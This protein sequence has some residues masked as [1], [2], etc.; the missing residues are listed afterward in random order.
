MRARS[1]LL[2]GFLLALGA[3][4][5]A[6]TASGGKQAIAAPAPIIAGFED[7]NFVSQ[8]RFTERRPDDPIVLP[9]QPNLSHDHSFFGNFNTNAY[10][11]TGSLRGQRTSCNRTADTAAYWAPTLIVDNKAALTLDLAAYYRRSTYAPVKP[12]PS[13]FVMIG[14]NSNAVE[15]QSTKVTFWN[16]EL[17]G[18]NPS[19]TIPNCGDKSLRLHV[20]F[21]ECW[22][23]KGL[24]SPNHKAHMAYAEDGV[25][26]ADHPVALPQLV[27]IIRYAASGAGNVVV[28]SGGQVSGHADFMNAWDQAG[29]TRLVDYCL[30]ALRPCGVER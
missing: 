24:D 12:F 15:P 20:I 3:I 30:N 26:P 4:V 5:I 14:G 22:D 6:T 9:A 18:T 29:L 19:P 17:A 1:V 10:S 27:L 25:C 16:C 2:V 28:A 23:G 21:P 11:T 13:D 8:C 7:V